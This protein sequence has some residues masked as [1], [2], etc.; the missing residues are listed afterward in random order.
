MS[1]RSRPLLYVRVIPE[2]ARDEAVQRVD[3]TDEVLSWEYQ[4][5]EKKADLLKLTVDN[6]TLANFDNPIWKKGNIVEVTWGYPGRMAPARRMVIDSVKGFQELSVEAHGLDMLMN[7]KVRCR[8]FEGLTRSQIAEQIA[9]EWGYG[10]DARYVQTTEEV[11]EV[12]TQ[13]Q[14]SDAAF[15]T[16]L[17]RQEGFLFFL[18][19]DGF[20]FHERMTGQQ[21][22]RTLTYYTDKRE[23]DILSISVENDITAKPGRVRAWSLELI[24][25]KEVAVDADGDSLPDPPPPI[26]ETPEILPPD[27][28]ATARS[29]FDEGVTNPQQTTGDPLADAYNAGVQDGRGWREA[30]AREY[31]GGGPAG[32][33]VAAARAAE[34]YA[35]GQ[36]AGAGQTS[37]AS[38]VASQP[39]ASEEVI[40]SSQGSYWAVR[41]SARARALAAQQTTVKLSIDIVGDPFFLAKSIIMVEGIGERL[42]G[43]YYVSDVTHK[44]GGEY[45]CSIACRSDGTRGY[46]TPGLPQAGREVRSSEAD[47][48]RDAGA[49][50]GVEPPSETSY[51]EYRPNDWRTMDARASYLTREERI[52]AEREV[53]ER[54]RA[55]RGY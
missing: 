49:L 17:A 3:L 7:K 39:S 2:G 41:R 43:R 1:D 28:G 51:R 55:L 29:S 9:E 30:V 46:R 11:L 34:H 45:T 42:S 37:V 38:Q 16:R 21:P 25:K 26:G 20:H 36:A 40:T 14:Q 50:L 8:A 32:L 35:R 4:D 33:A 22:Y 54:E 5:C 47:V 15:L 31:T 13:A 10:A 18:D 48:G 6:R 23:G 19:F 24:E 52:A 12:V 53:A 44:G 27:E